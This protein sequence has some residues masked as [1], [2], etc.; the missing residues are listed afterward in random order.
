M[1][2]LGRMP[3]HLENSPREKPSFINSRRLM[4]VVD[5]GIS[6]TLGN[7]YLK[8]ED[9]YYGVLDFFEEKGVGLPWSY[10][11]FLETKGIPALPFTLALLAVLAGGLFYAFSASTPQDVTF[12]ISL[13]DNKGRA[14]EDVSVRITDSRGRILDELTASNGQA[15]TLKGVAPNE[16]LTITATKQ[17]FSTNKGTLLVGENRFRL[18]LEGSNDAIVGKLKL[19]DSETQTT[20]T[21]AIVTAEWTGSRT[22][23]TA[24]PGS[25]GIILLNVPLDEEVSLSVRADN[26]EDLFDV[27]TFS[28]DDVKIKELTPKAS[29]TQGTSVLVVKAIDAKT[30]LPIEDVH[31]KIEHAQTGE[32][33]SDLDSTSGTHSENLSKGTVVRVSVSKE[34]YVAYTSNA[35]YPGG[36]TLRNEEELILAPLSFGGTALNVVTQ[37]ESS[38]QPLAGVELTLLD[39]DAEKIDSQTSNFSGE[40]AFPGLNETNTYTLLAYSSN[41][42]PKRI[43]VDLPSLATSESGKTLLLPL[44]P[45]VSGNAGTLTIFVSEKD[46]KAATQASISITEI[47]GEDYLPLV[48]ARTPDSAGSFTIRL[49]VGMKILVHAQKG[50][51]SEEEELT[52]TTGLN[53]VVLTLDDDAQLNTLTL[54]TGGKPFI[55]NVQLL[56]VSGNELFSGAVTDGEIIFATPENETISLIATDASGNK[57]TQT[58]SMGNAREKTIALDGTPTNGNA[59]AITFEGLFDVSGNPMAGIST[60]QD[61]FARFK[62]T[63]PASSVGAQSGSVMVRVGEDAVLSADSQFVGIIGVNGD[64]DTIAYGRSW[65]PTPVPGKESKD[66]STNGK[67]GTPNQWIELTVKKPL[68]TQTIDVRIAAREG[69]KAG[70]IPLH[71]RA[72]VNVGNQTLRTPNDA[73]LGTAPFNASK[74]GLYANT[75]STSVSVYDAL[76]FCQGKIC[77]TIQ[78]VDNENRTYPAGSFSPQEGKHYALQLGVQTTKATTALPTGSTSGEG[79]VP[80]GSVNA[81][82]GAINTPAGSA[83]IKISTPA[84]NPL[85][86]FTKSEINTFGPFSDTGTR[87]TSITFSL[88]GTQTANGSSARAHFIAEN[89]GETLITLQIIF[90]NESFTQTIPLRIVHAKQMNLTL[91]EVVEAGEKI[92]VRVQ[93]EDT[94]LITNALLTLTDASGKFSG[95]L[96]GTNTSGKG[97]QGTYV[98]DK[99]LEAGLY[100]LRVSAEG[101]AD[102]HAFVRVGVDTPLRIAEKITL[103][104]PFGQTTITQQVPITNTTKHAI[105]TIT[106]ELIELGKFPPELLVRVGT[107]PALAPGASGNIPITLA[108]EGDANSSK[109]ILGSATLRIHGT[110]A[111]AFPVN[112]TTILNAA[113]NPKLD[114][115]CVTFSKEKL[116]VSFMGDA[117]PFGNMYDGTSY[118]GNNYYGLTQGPPFNTFNSQGF[119]PYGFNA[120]GFYQ[121]AETKRVNVKVKNNCGETLNLVPGISQQDGQVAVDGLKIAVIDSAL[122][123]SNGQEKQVDF[124]VSNDLFRASFVGGGINYVATFSS[125]QLYAALP[126]EITFL[127]RTRAIQTVDAVEL[128]L[129]KTGTE[130]AVDRVNIPITN[131]GG[132]P[133][134]QLTATLQGENTPNVTI[135]LENAGVNTPTS[136]G[137]FGS[138]NNPSILLPGQTRFPPISIVAESLRDETSTV[139]KTLILTG[140]IEGRRFTLREIPIFVRTGSSSCLEVSAFDTPVSFVSSEIIGTLSKRITVKNNCVEPVRVTQ[141]AALPGIGTNRFSISPAE[142]SDIVEMG[143]EAE[144]NLVLEKSQAYKNEFTLQL[145]GLLMFTQRAIISNTLPVLVALGTNELEFSQASNPVQV[146]VC[147]GGNITVR[148]PILAKK[149]EC[150]QAYCDA[151]Q[152]G[153]YLAQTIEKQIAKATQQMQAKRNDATQFDA[154]DMTKRYCTFSQLG[155]TSPQLTLYLQ[156]DAL[157]SNMLSYVLRSGTYPR[158]ASLLVQAE[159][160]LVG[161]AADAA[162]ASRLGTGFGNAIYL[163]EINGCGVYTLSIIGG[164]EVVANQLQSDKVSIGI[165]LT[166]NKL[167]T[168]ECSDKIYNAAN[169]LPRDRSLSVENNQQTRAGVVEYASAALKEPAE[170]LAET[171]FGSRTRATQNSSSNRMTLNVGNLAQ[172]IVELTL[173]P[174][175]K[176]DGAKNIITVV[177]QTQGSVQKEAVVE[178]GKII[179]SLGKN[180]NGCIT[181][182]E[183]TWRIYSIADVGQFTYEGCSLANAADGGLVVRSNMACCSLNTRSDILSDVSYTLDPSGTQTIPGVNTLDLYEVGEPKSNTNAFAKPGEKISYGAAYP[184]TFN[185]TTQ[186]YGKEILLCG[187][188]DAYTMQQANGQRVQTIATRTLDDTRAGPLALELRTCTLDADDALAKAYEKGNGVWYATLDWDEDVASKTILQTL[189][190]ATQREKLGNAYVTYQGQGI[191]ANDNPY[192]QEQFKEKQLEALGGYGAACALACGVCAAGVTGLT[193]GLGSAI[194]WDCVVGC[195]LPTGI[196][197]AGVYSEEIQRAAEGTIVE[198]PT[199]LLV[200]GGA[201]LV[202]ST[203]QDEEGPADIALGTGLTYAA[204]RGT[205]KGVK[206]YRE[207]SAKVTS[208]FDKAQAAVKKANDAIDGDLKTA[209]K[210]LAEAKESGEKVVGELTKQLEDVQTELGPMEEKLA[211]AE[212]A[213]N[214]AVATREQAK[215]EFERVEEALETLPEQDPAKQ[216]ALASAQRASDEAARAA[217]AAKETVDRAREAVAAGELATQNTAQAMA[218]QQLIVENVTNELTRV[219]N[220]LNAVPDTTTI[221]RQLNIDT[222]SSNLN[223]RYARLQELKKEW[224]NLARL[225]KAVIKAEGSVGKKFIKGNVVTPEGKEHVFWKAVRREGDS[226]VFDLERV[227]EQGD[228]LI[229]GVP[230]EELSNYGMDEVA[231]RYRVLDPRELAE[232]T[233]KFSSEFTLLQNEIQDATQKLSAIRTQ[234][235]SPTVNNLVDARIT[236]LEQ[237]RTTATK[238]QDTVINSI[239]TRKGIPVSYLPKQQVNALS[240][241]LDVIVQS[242]VDEIQKAAA[243]QADVLIFNAGEARGRLNLLQEEMAQ[244]RAQADSLAAGLNELTTKAIAADNAAKVAAAQFENARSVAGA[245]ADELAELSAEFSDARLTLLESSDKMRDAQ[246]EFSNLRQELGERYNELGGSQADI[247]K[248]LEDAKKARDTATAKATAALEEAKAKKKLPD[249]VPGSKTKGLVK[250]VAKGLVCA[251]AGNVAGYFAYRG[252]ITDEVENKIELE[253]GSEAMLD[254]QTQEMTFLKGQTYQF[255][256]SPTQGEGKSSRMSIDI[257][258]PTT[259]VNPSAWMECE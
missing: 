256:V 121:N 4:S 171:V 230:I 164:V 128:T 71:Y 233:Q 227:T 241:G 96:K 192:Y 207:T 98:I 2:Y 143:Q 213:L 161:E 32:T 39:D 123:L 138:A 43:N 247:A 50:S 187:T 147:E 181:R 259:Q 131:I 218:Q 99:A 163:P 157:T 194:V 102:A 219:Q 91:D 28:N 246:A 174:R 149:D 254:A 145:N 116:S 239:S 81:G 182:D 67:A 172:S 139:S 97:E 16:T 169:F 209:E 84:E 141:V 118:T 158:L 166:R 136:A 35:E 53:K 165:K 176:G 173:D 114:A 7:A 127:D 134:T 73:V 41:F 240:N 62:I 210:A 133:I 238:A 66:R 9:A 198:T 5:M 251:G 120:A 15:I 27:I 243:A 203:L 183:Q 56:T 92:N 89:E 228:V 229:K 232:Y 177:R 180:V 46:G 144:F 8:V 255:S 212:D 236:E 257:V 137:G 54:T 244:A 76:P 226:F 234:N 64:A 113:Y 14:L 25:D 186:T 126:F 77:T 95:S 193:A 101:Y 61:A 253:A 17:G 40:A 235:I 48:V 74:S 87:D 250:S 140:T 160:S 42:F 47:S 146:N 156:N 49:P 11:D 65:N 130:K 189:A 90:N 112:A 70:N 208:E 10:N 57:F 19:V 125:P 93:G 168:A 154:C 196:A 122:Q 51:V 12:T 191:M 88:P 55:G 109:T 6:E 104:L 245:T 201:S 175:T 170:W 162:F 82:T 18:S 111:A 33:I 248:K 60:Q 63:W 68:G 1:H 231:E 58:F 26:Y 200:G 117:Q 75:L 252:T 3:P 129:I 78:F 103:T 22:P 188:A 59:P 52:I 107:I 21:S 36:K 184:L 79:L 222:V 83:T 242:R 178:A 202:E 224:D 29:A 237:F 214:Q 221:A 38:K 185:T 31:I 86:A 216:A 34:G 115:S 206:T 148:F 142:G 211:K 215:G 153:H 167:A 100:T 108:F 135:K 45:F 30:Q 205:L 220:T 20:I 94:A 37:S 159:P 105:S 258:S 13:T 72:L 249:A 225:E 110:A 197:A 150:S 124:E 69:V 85:L 24:T 80:P 199:N 195:G 204:G 190:E 152:A 223:A 217:Q 119:N 106:G 23:L 132:A 44:T 151:E 179:T 155:I